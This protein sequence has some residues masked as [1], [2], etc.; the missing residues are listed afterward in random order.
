MVYIST[1]D[2][3][4]YS[5]DGITLGSF[6]AVTVCPPIQVS[7]GWMVWYPATEPGSMQTYLSLRKPT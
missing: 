2:I 6:V 1:S 4:S 7:P 5:Q 3:D